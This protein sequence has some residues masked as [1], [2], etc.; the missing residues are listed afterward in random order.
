MWVILGQRFVWEICVGRLVIVREGM[1]RYNNVTG[2]G[3]ECV[4]WLVVCHGYVVGG[5][6]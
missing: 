4:L 6:A 3:G 5:S 1:D 2:V